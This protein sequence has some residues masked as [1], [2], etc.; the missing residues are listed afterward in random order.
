MDSENP[1]ETFDCIDFIPF[2]ILENHQILGSNFESPTAT[3]PFG[4]GVFFATVFGRLAHRVPFRWPCLHHHSPHRWNPKLLHL[5]QRRKWSSRIHWRRF[6]FL[7]SSFRLFCPSCCF[8][9]LLLLNVGPP[10]NG[11]WHRFNK[12]WKQKGCGSG[13]L[14]ADLWRVLPVGREAQVDVHQGLI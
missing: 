13:C 2:H 5:R 9:S 7:F 4:G 14:L 1:R 8:Y 3:S 12:R 10:R 6:L 11:N